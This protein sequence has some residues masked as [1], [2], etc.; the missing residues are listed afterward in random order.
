VFPGEPG[1]CDEEKPGH[2]YVAPPTTASVWRT[3]GDASEQA[4]L[5]LISESSTR[6]AGA[7]QRERELQRAEVDRLGQVLVEAGLQRAPPVLGKVQG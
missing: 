7:L 5:D 3:R 2:F 6:S 1:L 4:R